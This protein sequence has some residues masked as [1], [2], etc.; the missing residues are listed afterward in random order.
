[1][2]P[3]HSAQVRPAIIAVAHSRNWSQGVTLVQTEV[4]RIVVIPKLVANI[5]GQWLPISVPGLRLPKAITLD[6]GV[7]QDI[8]ISAHNVAT[9][10]SMPLRIEWVPIHN[11]STS[12][13][14][15]AL[16]A[17][18]LDWGHSSP[19]RTQI[20]VSAPWILWGGVGYINVSL[21]NL[22]AT[23]APAAAT[24]QVGNNITQLDTGVPIQVG[25]VAKVGS[26][27]LGPLAPGFHTIVVSAPGAKPV[28]HQVVD[29]PPLPIVMAAFGFSMAEVWNLIVR[30]RK[31]R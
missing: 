13:T 28:P 17:L 25:G 3:M 2:I 31:G 30:K 15:V 6:F 27:M 14:V 11:K 19:V 4:P 9:P 10:P 8:S 26:A 1:M 7:A 23:W 18:A 24:V 16:P 29:I 20:S 21:K 12:T 5:R 22:G